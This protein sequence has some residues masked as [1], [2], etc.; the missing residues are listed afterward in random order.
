MK[1]FLLWVLCGFLGL[2]VAGFGVLL[3]M[4]HRDGAGRS[5]ASIEIAAPPDAVWTWLNDP[6]KVKQWV[7]WLVEVRSPAPDARGVG[8]KQVWVMRDENSGG[9]LMEVEGT[10]TEFTPPARMTVHTATAGAFDGDQVYRLTDLGHNHT[11]LDMDS[12]Y[13]FAIW[14]ARLMEPLVTTQVKKKMIADLGHLK[15]L[16]EGETSQA[17]R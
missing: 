4:S 17:A 2:L 14:L 15:T 12:Q 16:A 11:R 1:K 9:Q 5:Q 8:V 7:S 6:A 3:A 10:I 13:H